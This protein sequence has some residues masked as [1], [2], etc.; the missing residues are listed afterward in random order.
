MIPLLNRRDSEAGTLL[1]QPIG[2]GVTI[3]LLALGAYLFIVVVTT[4][5]LPPLYAAR[6]AI[7]LNWWVIS[8]VTIGSGVQAYLISYS[9]SRACNPRFKKPL[10]GSTGTFSALSSFLSYLA[11]VP[12]GCCGTWLYII[13]FLPGILGAN[14]SGFLVEN[15]R[16]L[17]TVSLLIM[18]ASV[19]YT[20]LSVR[21]RLVR[22]HE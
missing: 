21:R 19:S 14:A 10:A 18:I 9:K 13:S 20:Y 16:V 6:V 17:A 1:R 3:G 15:G 5:S 11:L 12:V 7:A 4:P 2:R 8:G 22:R